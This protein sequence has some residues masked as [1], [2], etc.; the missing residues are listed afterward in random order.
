MPTYIVTSNGGDLLNNVEYNTGQGDTL[1]R[2][3]KGTQPLK[4][5]SDG[6]KTWQ[7]KVPVTAERTAYVSAT[8]Q[9]GHTATCRIIL[10]GKQIISQKG[11]PGTRVTC[12][13]TAPPMQK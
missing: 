8:P 5:S 10:G 12:T 13:K 3:H 2:V 11:E 7:T 6:A 9:P 4:Q 1:T